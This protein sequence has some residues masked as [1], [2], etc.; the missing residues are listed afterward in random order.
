M[1]L[2][3]IILAV[4][5]LVYIYKFVT[6]PDTIILFLK[7]TA[8]VTNSELTAGKIGGAVFIGAFVM[9]LFLAA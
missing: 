7:E 9:L 4:L 1:G 6:T 8:S 5:A 2:L 3:K